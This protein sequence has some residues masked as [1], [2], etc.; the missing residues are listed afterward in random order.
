MFSSGFYLPYPYGSSSHPLPPEE[1]LDSWLD[2]RWGSFRGFEIVP[3]RDEI[4]AFT[5]PLGTREVFFHTSD[6]SLWLSDKQ[7]TWRSMASA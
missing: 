7:T 4:T 6:G 3:A 5:D 1:P 2:A